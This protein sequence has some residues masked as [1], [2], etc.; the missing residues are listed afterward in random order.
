MYKEF[1]C[2][3]VKITRYDYEAMPCPM[4]AKEIDDDVMQKIANETY[5]ELLAYGW[6]EKQIRRY[7]DR[8]SKEYSPILLFEENDEADLIEDNFWRIMEG[9]AIR[10]GM[11]YYEDIEEQ[12]EKENDKLQTVDG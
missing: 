11:R 12:E 4:F 3:G 10:N 8:E 5:D 2:N 1:S 7:L 9:A 6:S